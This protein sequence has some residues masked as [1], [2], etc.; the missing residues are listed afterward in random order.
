VTRRSVTEVQEALKGL[1]FDP[2]PI[3]GDAGPLTVIALKDFQRR[4]GLLVDGLY[5]PATEAAMDFALGHETLDFQGTRVRLP[6]PHWLTLARAE[7]GTVEG[8][9]KANNPK[10]LRYFADAGFAGVHDD[11]VAWCAAFVGAMLVR[12]G[13]APSHS[14]AARSY[15]V[16]GVP[17]ARPLLGCVGTKRRNGSAWQGHTGFVVGASATK[18]FLL[19]GNTGNAVNIAAFNRDEFTSFRWPHNAL[20]STG[21]LPTNIAD[22]RVGAS[23]A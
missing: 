19:G 17:A 3:D 10:V 12:A 5:G 6:E 16:W 20:P 11:E 15:D 1:G 7:V 18:I 2:G 22:A 14:L 8:I 21:E 4:V 9:G 23:E 13:I